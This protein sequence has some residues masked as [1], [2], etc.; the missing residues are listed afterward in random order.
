MKCFDG[1][2]FCK[3]TLFSILTNKGI[4]IVGFMRLFYITNEPIEMFSNK[5]YYVYCFK[6]SV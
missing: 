5:I 1:K 6:C 4:L 3:Y 2:Q